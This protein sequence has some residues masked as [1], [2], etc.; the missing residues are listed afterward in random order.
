MAIV[1]WQSGVM[2]FL[3]ALLALAL[4][5]EIHD[6]NE[7]VTRTAKRCLDQIPAKY[8]AVV[9]SIAD[10]PSPLFCVKVLI[11]TI[12]DSVIGKVGAV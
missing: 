9:A 2:T 10:S 1:H 11:K 3:E 6:S 5:A 4:A 12:P 7:A 8:K